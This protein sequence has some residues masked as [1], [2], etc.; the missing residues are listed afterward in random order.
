[1][2][3]PLH[4]ILTQNTSNSYSNCRR[5][6]KSRDIVGRSGDIAGV[7]RVP[8]RH[9]VQCETHRYQIKMKTVNEGC[10]SIDPHVEAKKHSIICNYALAMKLIIV[11]KLQSQL[12]V[13]ANQTTVTKA[14]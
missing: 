12:G 9:I 8:S 7:A 6:Y 1:M 10:L 4:D 13:E 5:R 2:T 14:N 11:S 3:L